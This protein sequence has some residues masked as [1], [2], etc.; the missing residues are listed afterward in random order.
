MME[1]L[2]PVQQRQVSPQGNINPPNGALK[3]HGDIAEGYD[4]KRVKDDK[5]IV[6]QAI[7]ERMLSELPAGSVVLDCPVGTGRFLDCYK[8]KGLHFVG[9]DLSGD[10]LIQSALKLLP[11]KE[12]ER[13][14]A[15]CNEKSVVLPLRI[16]KDALVIGDIRKIGL[17]NKAVDAAVMCRLTRWLSPEDNQVAMRQ[18]MRVTKSCIIWTA[19]VANHPHARTIELF[20]TALH[21]GGW[22]IARN[23]AGY[24]TDY[25]ILM[26]VPA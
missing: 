13:W 2:P 22:K 8:S 26:A 24:I 6:E 18:L 17:E 19:R 3:Y 1:Y 15:A 5:W 10:M 20:E 23:E 12:V 25:R 9:A 16:D 21:A 11:E 7:I 4:A 14:V